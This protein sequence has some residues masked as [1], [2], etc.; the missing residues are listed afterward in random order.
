MNALEN[1]SDALWQQLAPLLDETIDSL[2]AAD[3]KAILLRFF[4][5]RDFQSIGAALGISDDAAQKRVSRALE[6]LR[7]LLANRGVMLSAALLAILMA[8]KAV[9]GALVGT[10]AQVATV[11]LADA[12]PACSTTHSHEA[13]PCGFVLCRHLRHKGFLVRFGISHAQ[14]K[15]LPTA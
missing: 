8:G 10:A 2:D 15:K 4:E 9:S 12:V 14:T 5:R 3:R 13:G 11:A 7:S 1:S 6:K